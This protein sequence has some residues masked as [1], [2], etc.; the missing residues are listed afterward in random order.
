MAFCLLSSPCS[1]VAGEGSVSG[2]LAFN[3]WQGLSSHSCGD[4]SFKE[5]L[6]QKGDVRAITKDV[7]EGTFM[8]QAGMCVSW[9]KV[10]GWTISN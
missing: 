8:H 4:K 6:I 1:S 10:S 9:C 2:E 3:S 5:R 7:V